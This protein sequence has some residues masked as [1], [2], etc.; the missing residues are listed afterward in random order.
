MESTGQ[1]TRNHN[2]RG[3]RLRVRQV[4]TNQY[5]RPD[6]AERGWGYGTIEGNLSEEQLLNNRRD[7]NID[8]AANYYLD[9]EYYASKDYNMSDINVPVLSVANWGGILLHL[10]GNVEGY[11]NAGSK[12]KYLRFITGR[13]DLPFY[14]K[15]NVEMQKSFLDAFLKD[16]DTAGWSTGQVPRI[17]IT[18]RKGDVGYNDAEAENQYQ[19]RCEDQWPI[20]RTKYTKY[21]LTASKTL[22]AHRVDGQEGRLS[23]QAP[24]SLKDPQT[25]Q[26]STE[27]FAEEV[28]FTG[29]VVAHLS[30]SCSA[31]SP[32]EHGLSEIDIFTTIRHLDSTGK[33]IYYT[34][35]VGDPVPV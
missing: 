24:G 5:G 22:T 15:E 4:V 11:M 28:E 13:H 31:L 26:F 20:P 3:Q 25:I 6:R 8:N 27:P 29:N 9:E 14:T 12:L 1:C 32:Q 2:R 35:T 34:G 17:G 16:V 23:Y 33:E 30:V 19:H 18:L 7:Q 21:H 10:R